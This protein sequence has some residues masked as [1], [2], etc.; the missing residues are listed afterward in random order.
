MPE[1]FACCW[2]H[3]L[4]RGSVDAVC[5]APPITQSNSLF[6][7][8]GCPARMADSDRHAGEGNGWAGV[9]LCIWILARNVWVAMVRHP[10]VDTEM[11]KLVGVKEEM[12]VEWNLPVADRGSNQGG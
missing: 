10:G 3:L 12:I 7:D 5:L 8:P 6:P 4:E 11:Q 2:G 9:V 1:E